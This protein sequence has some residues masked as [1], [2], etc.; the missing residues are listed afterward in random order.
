VLETQEIARCANRQ[1]LGAV[2]GGRRR[3]ET[4]R[5]AVRLPL[6][7]LGFAAASKLYANVLQSVTGQN[8]YKFSLDSGGAGRE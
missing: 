5:F 8:S 4:T 1:G 3:E 6:H 2:I 7:R